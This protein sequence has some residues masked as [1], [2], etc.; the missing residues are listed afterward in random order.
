MEHMGP[1]MVQVI[2]PGERENDTVDVT[3]F[4]FTSQLHSLLSDS[5]L[6]VKDNLVVNEDDPFTQYKSPNGL[7][8]ECITGSWYN[9][10]WAHMIANTSCNFMIPIILYIDK[11]Q[12]SISGKL[13][14]FPV[15]MS[16]GIFTE[17]ARRKS[18][19]W[20]PL[21]YIANENYYFST[22]ICKKKI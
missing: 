16:L 11:T 20:R 10:A 17:V 7:L 12:M 21:G 19:A 4:N 8:N 3:T 15:Q 13:S 6:N 22:A 1:S 5:N 2:L 18:N 9:H 14:L